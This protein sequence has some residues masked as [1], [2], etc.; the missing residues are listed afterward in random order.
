MERMAGKNAR[1]LPDDK[2]EFQRWTVEP[3]DAI[4]EMGVHEV[5]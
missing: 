3:R 1:F 4:A 5:I 2:W